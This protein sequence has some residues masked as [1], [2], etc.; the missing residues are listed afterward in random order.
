VQF[1]SDFSRNLV[2]LGALDYV[3]GRIVCILA[4]ILLRMVDWQPCF[5]V[6]TSSDE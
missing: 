6:D 2:G 5:D 1:S 4:L 3:M